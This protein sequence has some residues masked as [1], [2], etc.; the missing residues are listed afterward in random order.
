MF[1]GILIL[2]LLMS[3]S[4]AWLLGSSGG[5]IRRADRTT[6]RSS[7]RIHRKRRSESFVRFNNNG[8]CKTIIAYNKNDD[9]EEEDLHSFDSMED[10]GIKDNMNIDQPNNTKDVR[11]SHKI[12]TPVAS[13][14][15]GERS[16]QEK[17]VN[18]LFDVSDIASLFFGTAFTVG[19][20]LNLCG[21]GYTFEDG[22]HLR[23]DRLEQFRVEKQFREAA[24]ELDNGR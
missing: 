8:S 2:L 16:L 11:G 24:Q 18:R 13:K 7:T 20:L 23:I 22:A 5:L 21:Y 6:P 12:D 4:S 1:Y 9:N 14:K 19:L 3:P 15:Q 10:K 17:M